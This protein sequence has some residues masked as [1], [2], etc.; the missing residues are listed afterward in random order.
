MSNLSAFLSE[1]IG[2]SFELMQFD[3]MSLAF[4]AFLALW[5]IGFV[6]FLIKVR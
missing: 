4:W 3:I 2:S 1:F 6:F 5:A